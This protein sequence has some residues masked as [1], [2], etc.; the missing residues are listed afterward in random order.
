MILTAKQLEN[1]KADLLQRIQK[2]KGEYVTNA[3][4][5]LDETA[6]FY[7]DI[8]RVQ[9]FDYASKVKITLRKRN[10]AKTTVKNPSSEL[11]NLLYKVQEA[12]QTQNSAVYMPYLSTKEKN[13]IK[14]HNSF[15][16]VTD[17][18]K[19]VYLSAKGVNALMKQNGA[20]KTAVNGKSVVKRVNPKSTKTPINARFLRYMQK[21][22]DTPDNHFSRNFDDVK[23]VDA[24]KFLTEYAKRKTTRKPNHTNADFNSFVQKTTRANSRM[25]QGKTSGEKLQLIAPNGTP[26]NLSRLGQLKLM[27]VKMPNG[28]KA[29]ITFDND[30]FL[31]M[32]IRKNLHCVGKGAK[33][34]GVKVVGNGLAELGRLVQIDYVT[35]KKHINGNQLTHFYHKLGEVTGE[36]PRLFIDKEKFPIIH[37]GNYDVWNVG[38]VN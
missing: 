4:S 12:K 18:G 36:T 3:T 9:Y 1:N 20:T 21:M 10:G 31:V 27:I 24:K 8:F 2:G 7:D 22:A 35:D 11:L 34:N 38:I 17:G 13:L 29:N 6:R 16:R 32:D 14:N 30:A 26:K 25:F 19:S 37:G 33:I 5:M 23:Q 15:F 28:E